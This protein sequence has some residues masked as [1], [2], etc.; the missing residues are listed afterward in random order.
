MKNIGKLTRVAN[1]RVRLDAID[2]D[3]SYAVPG[4]SAAFVAV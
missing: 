4:A 2:V 3:P 1:A